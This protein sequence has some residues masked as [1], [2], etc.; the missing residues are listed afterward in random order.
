ML[1]FALYQVIKS[2]KGPATAEPFP[3]SKQYKKNKGAEGGEEVDDGAEDAEG[4]SDQVAEG[5]DKAT[6]AAVLKTKRAQVKRE[7]GPKPSEKAAEVV[8]T[9]KWDY[10]RVKRAYMEKK[11]VPCTQGWIGR[12][13]LLESYEC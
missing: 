12:S 13:G 4:P 1:F 6:S 7:D 8:V 2:L 5:S 3:I 11:R 9:P 10:A